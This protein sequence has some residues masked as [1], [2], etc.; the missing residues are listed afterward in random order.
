MIGMIQFLVDLEHC[1]QN[2]RE[3][4]EKRASKE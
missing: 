1:P 4:C 3:V 2:M